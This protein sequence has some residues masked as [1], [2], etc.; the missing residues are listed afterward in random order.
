[1]VTKKPS[2]ISQN[3]ARK[4]RATTHFTLHD[5]FAEALTKVTTDTVARAV[6]ERDRQLKFDDLI[7]LTIKEANANSH[8]LTPTAF[9]TVVNEILNQ[10]VSDN[11]LEGV[12]PPPE[13]VIAMVRR[14]LHA[15]KTVPQ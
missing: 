8:T 7:A 12:L 6:S 13:R 14:H 1:M 9:A 2:P 3:V 5:G 11:I 4:V 15:E 10:L